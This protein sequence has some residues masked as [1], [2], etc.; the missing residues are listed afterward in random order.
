MPEP[1][2]QKPKVMDVEIVENEESENRGAHRQRVW[3]SMGGGPY[4]GG[5]WTPVDSGGC[6]A[7]A[8]TFA[9]FVI[10]LGQF[11]L[12][13]AIGFFVF[14]II[15]AILG[16]IYQARQ[17][18]AGFAC[19]PWAWRTGNWIISFMLTTWLAGGFND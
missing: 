17:L 2:Q 8:I 14:H 11:G 12:L 13:A 3:T 16:T 5:Y 18:M 9:L 19:N 10:S 1:E 7:P 6:V 15:G 4:F